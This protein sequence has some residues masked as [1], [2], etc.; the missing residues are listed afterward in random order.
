MSFRHGILILLL[1]FFVVLLG[2]KN[3]EVWTLPI[4]LVPVK[5]ETKKV[6]AKVE[7]PSATGGKKEPTPIESYIFVAE[8]NIFTPER[9]EFPVIA[10]PSVAEVKKPIVRPQVILYG[11]T[12][13]GD[14]ESASVTN[15][16]R[17][18]RKGER[19]LMTLKIGDRVGDYKLAKILPD[20]I[21][22][23]AEGDTFEVLLYDPKVPK[24]RAYGKTEVKPATITSTLATPA[25][26]G[27]APVASSA[28]PPA[29]APARPSPVAP[30]RPPAGGATR[31]Q[32]G[33]VPGAP[34]RVITPQTPTPATPPG[35][36]P[37]PRPRMRR[38][39]SPFGP[40]DSD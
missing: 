2:L 24:Q 11:V 17:Q 23:E 12:I 8:K 22:M 10:P 35:A 40:A 20:R 36:A 26:P 5:G 6:G 25:A 30:T 31:G 4:E 33:V 14:Y 16:G 13:V 1:F 38:E 32:A 29:V 39:P 27:A 18:P 37:I 19:E 3:Y 34:D 7:T 15:P 28:R 21:T 9:K